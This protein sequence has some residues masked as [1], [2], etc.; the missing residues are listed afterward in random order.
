QGESLDARL[1]RLKHLPLGHVLRIGREVAEGLALAH[2]Q[3][4]IH[5]DIKPGNIWLERRPGKRGDD[6]RVKI[7][8]FGL[9]RS[10]EE[11]GQLTHSGVIIG[12]P[13][14]MA[15]EQAAGKA[16]DARSDLFSLGAVLYALATGEL[17][18]K[19][20]HTLAIL[21]SLATE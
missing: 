11:Q 10:A 1:K 15:P 7:L 8:D 2:D 18:F 12:T 4:L 3:G 5:R 13:A 20:E 19:G 16:V 21:S 14:Y 17:P 6:F 9:A